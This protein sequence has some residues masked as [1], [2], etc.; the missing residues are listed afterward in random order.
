MLFLPNSQFKV[1]A[2]LESQ[3]HKVAALEEL[4]AYNMD[5]LHVYVLTQLS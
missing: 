4:S 2:R 3:A 5:S 1:T